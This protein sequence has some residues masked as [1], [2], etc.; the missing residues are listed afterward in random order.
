M[1][2]ARCGGHTT[3]APQN[4]FQ[5]NLDH[6]GILSR[7]ANNPFQQLHEEHGLWDGLDALSVLAKIHRLMY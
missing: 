5:V 2:P 4:L 6:T 7:K 1:T 3:P